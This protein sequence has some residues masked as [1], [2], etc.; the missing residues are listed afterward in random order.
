MA[1]CL[2]RMNLNSPRSE[3]KDQP[4]ALLPPSTSRRPARRLKRQSPKYLEMMSQLHSMV[5]C[6][7]NRTPR[8]SS[9]K[10]GEHIRLKTDSGASTRQVTCRAM[11]NGS[12]A[13][14][15]RETFD[16]CAKISLRRLRPRPGIKHREHRRNHSAE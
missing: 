11:L 3:Y 16:R 9:L 14:R 8:T 1:P 2:Q 15:W 12:H 10:T 13:S 5:A 4:Q 7:R 6:A